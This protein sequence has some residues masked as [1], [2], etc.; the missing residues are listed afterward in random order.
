MKKNLFGAVAAGLA[1]ALAITSFGCESGNDDPIARLTDADLANVTGQKFVFEVTPSEYKYFSGS[2]EE[3]ADIPESG[4]A[5]STAYGNWVWSNYEN[6]TNKW[7]RLYGTTSTTIAESKRESEL[8]KADGKSVGSVVKTKKSTIT[9]N[10]K[11]NTWTLSDSSTNKE[12]YGINRYST[13]YQTTPAE[14]TARQGYAAYVTIPAYIG[15]ATAGGGTWNAF[16][17]AY[18]SSTFDV[19]PGYVT[20]MQDALTILEGADGSAGVKKTISDAI[21]LLKDAPEGNKNAIKA[22]EAELKKCTDLIT[23]LYAEK[24]AIEKSLLLT[25]VVLEESTVDGATTSTKTFYAGDKDLVVYTVKSTSGTAKAANSGKYKVLSGNYITGTLLVTSDKDYT[26]DDDNDFYMKG[27]W[28]GVISVDFPVAKETTA[29][30]INQ[31]AGRTFSINN[32]VLTANAVRLTAT[33]VG[34]Y[35]HSFYLPSSITSYADAVS[36]AALT[37]GLMNKYTKSYAFTRK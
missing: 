29:G 14:Y 26:Y 13:A 12:V 19:T 33:G 10:A 28:R 25:K 24:A 37:S 17:A 16:A 2:T 6:G 5:A 4:T 23:V 27:T 22:A 30:S 31:K 32:N 9:L 35:T 18:T 11:D 36:Q 3:R 15:S 21:T 20:T 34:N 1:L 8:S 7:N